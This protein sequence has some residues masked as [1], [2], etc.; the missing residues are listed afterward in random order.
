MLTSVPRRTSH[1]AAQLASSSFL[2]E[3]PCLEEAL[4]AARMIQVVMDTERRRELPPLAMSPADLPDN[5]PSISELMDAYALSRLVIALEWKFL[6]RGHNWPKWRQADHCWW[7]E[8][9]SPEHED[10]MPELDRRM[11]RARYRALVIGAA[12]AGVYNEPMFKAREVTPDLELDKVEETG[13]L[14][15]EQFEFL[16]QFA[17]CR[18]DQTLSAM[19]RLLAW[20]LIAPHTTTLITFPNSWSASRS[21]H[22]TTWKVKI[23][24]S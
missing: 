22:L 4:I 6:V 1:A 5:P 18:V 16:Q 3:I 17:V 8:D 19:R 20:P 7:E 24:K 9:H 23:V 12:L 13:E 10:D 14:S 15:E 11:R 21:F 2:R